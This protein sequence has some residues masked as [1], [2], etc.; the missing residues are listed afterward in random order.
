[1]LHNLP[2]V[3][4]ELWQRWE[5]QGSSGPVDE[6]SSTERAEFAALL[7]SQSPVGNGP[8]LTSKA[9]ASRGDQGRQANGRGASTAKLQVSSDAKM[10]L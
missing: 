9:E 1:M 7:A 8:G 3:F 6:T 4:R 2:Q 10:L 5:G